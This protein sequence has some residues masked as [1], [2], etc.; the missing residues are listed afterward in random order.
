M[1][2]GRPGAGFSSRAHRTHFIPLGRSYDNT[3][4]VACQRLFPGGWLLRHPMPGSYSNSRLTV[5][6]GIGATRVVGMDHAGT[7]SRSW[8]LVVRARWRSRFP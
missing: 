2:S 6:A 5:D 7:V 8:Q 4:P 3:A 1:A